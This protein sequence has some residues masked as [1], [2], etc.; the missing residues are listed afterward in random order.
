MSSEV[1]TAVRYDTPGVVRSLDVGAKALL[2]L[3]LGLALA[4]PEASGLEGKG[5]EARAIGYPLLAFSIPAVWFFYWR[6]RASFPWLPD[7]LVTLTCFSDTLGNRMDLYNR[8]VWFD[9]WMHFVNLGL[10]TAAVLLLTMHRSA[11][12]GAV[13]ERS[14]AFAATAAIAWELAE[15][16]A[17]LSRHSERRHA[18]ADTLGDLVLGVLGAVVAAG[19]VHRAWAAGRLRSTA[20][21][22]EHAAASA[23]AVG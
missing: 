3:L 7:L 17:F 22:L 2:V 4:H 10:L 12:L 11:G 1:V 21:Q 14:L 13:V 16:A 15:Y 18:Y 9:D 8:I 6:E 5:A 19:V 20:P 23:R